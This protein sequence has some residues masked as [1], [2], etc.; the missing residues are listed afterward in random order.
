MKQK[1]LLVT[2]TLLTLLSP[3]PA[4]ATPAKCIKTSQTTDGPYYTEAITQSNISSSQN[5]YKV[6]YKLKIQNTLCQ[7]LKGLTISLWQA[8]SQG[9]YTL[10]KNSLRG[11]QTTN[12]EGFVTYESIFPGW[13]PTRAS[14]IHVKI[15]SKDKKTLLSTQLFFPQQLVNKIYRTKP[16]LSR[17]LEQITKEKDQIYQSLPNP[18]DMRYTAPKTLTA[19]ITL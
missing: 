13:Y 4:N 7:P 1:V 3:S 5:G 14:H 12:K 6:L 8:N 9:E 15:I 2:L 11:N 10:I 16:Y 18:V 19:T 17:G